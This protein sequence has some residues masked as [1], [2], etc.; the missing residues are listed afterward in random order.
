MLKCGFRFQEY[1]KMW[2]QEYVKNVNV[3]NMESRSILKYGAQEYFKIQSP[4]VHILKYGAQEYFKI[5]SVG[6][7]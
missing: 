7:C 4:G 3:K 5:W 6:V 1:V 2:M